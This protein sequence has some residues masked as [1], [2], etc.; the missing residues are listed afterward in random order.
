M[1]TP[2]S[3]RALASRTRART[4][5]PAPWL[6][7]PRLG[8]TTQLQCYLA[9]LTPIIPSDAR[10]A[11]ATCCAIAGPAAGFPPSATARGTGLL[12]CRGCF[13]GVAPGRQPRVPRRGCGEGRVRL[14]GVAFWTG[15]RLRNKRKCVSERWGRPRPADLRAR[16]QRCCGRVRAPR[17]PTVAPLPTSD[18]FVDHR[19]LSTLAP[20]V[21]AGRGV[22]EPAASAAADPVA[23]VNSVAGA[24]LAWC[25]IDDERSASRCFVLLCLCPWQP[26]LVHVPPLSGSPTASSL[27]DISQVDEI[28]ER[29]LHARDG[30]CECAARKC[31]FD[32]GRCG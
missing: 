16:T 12:R 30:R 18:L 25:G 26:C 1:A 3:G 5:A 27:Q 20:D 14:S 31:K 17:L 13:R 24:H 10:L 22:P 4:Y 29:L 11:S 21:A 2:A 7:H 8:F 28:I 23:A 6:R 15:G 19:A 9:Q 32:D